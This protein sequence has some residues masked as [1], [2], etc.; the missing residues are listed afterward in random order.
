EPRKYSRLPVKICENHDEVLFHIYR[1]I[2]GR[3][4]PYSGTTLIHFDSHPDMTI[5]PRLSA[6]LVFN[7]SELMEAL[8]IAD[9]ILP[10]VYAGHI[11]RVVW[12]KPSWCDQMTR[13]RM[14]FCVGKH[15]ESGFLRVTS[16]EDYFLEELL[17]APMEELENVKQVE[18]VILTAELKQ[19][20]ET[21]KIPAKEQTDTYKEVL[22]S[23]TAGLSNDL[24]PATTCQHS[25]ALTEQVKND[26]QN[27]F[28]RLQETAEGV[29]EKVC[30][31]EL[32]LKLSEVLSQEK[33]YILDI[34]MDFFSTSNP[35]KDLF[36]E[37]E[38]QTLQDIY[39]F[40]PPKTS[41]KAD[42][43]ICIKSRQDQLSCI[44]SSFCHAGVDIEEGAL[45]AKCLSRNK[46]LSELI[47]Q[48]QKR[49]SNADLKLLHSAGM[50]IDLPQ[51]ISSKPEIDQLMQ[52][53]KTV[54]MGIPRPTM[55]TT[56]R[57]SYDEYTPVY[58]VEYIQSRLLDVL[59]SVYGEDIDVELDYEKDDSDSA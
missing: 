39:V 34:D 55:V 17:Y 53:V 13:E 46:Q 28:T 12:I 51:H 54:I 25:S 26:S 20:L 10:A 48:V 58:Q 21:I 42:L 56:A 15:R 16:T 2:A 23:A 22:K 14:T 32:V 36:T 6:S 59:R 38:F 49:D 4:L 11:D 44:E 3:Y 47:K 41:S 45:E 35:F 1:A 50:A 9:W 52:T 8:S 24:K 7:P 33:L 5:P 30:V 43:E 29:T 40:T 18:L 37:E 57:S 31:N 27:Y 19:I